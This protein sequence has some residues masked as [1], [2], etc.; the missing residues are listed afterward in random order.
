[1]VLVGGMGVGEWW[2]WC[3]QPRVVLQAA[4]VIWGNKQSW[5]MGCWLGTTPG[6][7]NSHRGLDKTAWGE[8]ECVRH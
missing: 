8:N 5:S 6:R 2:R 4:G 3:P 1:M 7:R